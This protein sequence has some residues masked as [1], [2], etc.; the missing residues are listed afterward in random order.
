MTGLKRC[1]RKAVP[2]I[3]PPDLS[4]GGWWPKLPIYDQ[5][6]KAGDEGG[7][8]RCQPR[9]CET[10]CP[11]RLSTLPHLRILA[12]LLAL[13]DAFAPVAE[14]E[15]HIHRRYCEGAAWEKRTVIGSDPIQRA[16]RATVKRGRECRS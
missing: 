12:C 8:T 7:I 11:H 13:L 14:R 2:Q 6:G 1:F 10:A 16:R 15:R 5:V 9:R 3:P 4:T